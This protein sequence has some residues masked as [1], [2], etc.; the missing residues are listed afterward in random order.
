METNIMPPCSLR[1]HTPRSP[2]PIPISL[3]NS[4]GRLITLFTALLMLNTMAILFAPGCG[5]SGYIPSSTTEQQDGDVNTDATT[6]GDTGLNDEGDSQAPQTLEAVISAHPHIINEGADTTTIV[7]L[8]GS[9]SRNPAGGTL[10]YTWDVPGCTIIEGTL[11]SSTIRCAFTGEEPKEL[12]LTVATSA[13]GAEPR[14]ATCN[15]FLPLNLKPQV[16][17]DAPQSANRNTPAII[18]ATVMDPETGPTE[19]HFSLGPGFPPGASLTTV[20]ETQ[21]ELLSPAPGKVTINATASDTMGAT[22]SSSITIAITNQAPILDFIGNRTVRAGTRLSFTTTASDP[23][24]DPVTFLAENLPDRATYSEGIFIWDTT[25][26]HIGSQTITFKAWDGIDHSQED[27]TLTVLTIPGEPVLTLSPPDLY[28]RIGA[29]QEL[30]IVAGAWTSAGTVAAL[31]ASPLPTGATFTP[32]TG[33]FYWTPTPDQTGTH[34]ITFKVTAGAKSTQSTVTIM[35]TPAEN[36]PPILAMNPDHLTWTISEG[37]KMEFHIE[38]TDPDGDQVT[39]GVSGLPANA[40]FNSQG[41]TGQ[42]TFTPSYSQAGVL[43]MII[44]ASDGHLVT[45]TTITIAIADV[46]RPPTMNI[47]PGPQV[48]ALTGQVV[49]LKVNAHDPDGDTVQ[50]QLDQSPLGATMDPATAILTWT[51]GGHQL[52]THQVIFRAMDNGNPPQ[53]TTATAVINVRQSNRS[54]VVT[55]PLPP[56]EIHTGGTV[57]ID[58][59]LYFNDPDGDTLTYSLPAKPSWVTI[60]PPSSFIFIS[61]RDPSLAMGTWPVTARASDGKA[62]ADSTF[63]VSVI[64]SPVGTY[65]FHE[66]ATPGDNNPDGST[67]SWPIGSIH[68][69]VMGTAGDELYFASHHDGERLAIHRVHNNAMSPHK[70][71]ER[72]NRNEFREAFRSFGTFLP[73]AQGKLAFIGHTWGYSGVFIID[74]AQTPVAPPVALVRQ[75]YEAPGGLRIGTVGMDSITAN[76]DFG[77]CG[78][79]FGLPDQRAAFVYS[80]GKLRTASSQGSAAP[81]GGNFSTCFGTVLMGGGGHVAFQANLSG[82]KWGLFVWKPGNANGPGVGHGQWKAAWRSDGSYSF[83]ALTAINQFMVRADGSVIFEGSTAAGK[84]GIFVAPFTD[85]YPP[86]KL[87]MEG[88]TIQGSG[89][90]VSSCSLFN[91]RTNERSDT[92]TVMATISFDGKDGDATGIYSIHIETGEVM[93]VIVPG[94]R[95]DGGLQLADVFPAA[96]SSPDSD[97][98]IFGFQSSPSGYAGIGMHTTES[99]QSATVSGAKAQS[100]PNNIIVALIGDNLPDGSQFSTPVTTLGNDSGTVY[101]QQTAGGTVFRGAAEQQNN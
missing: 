23:D 4:L 82:G 74:M 89:D 13:S 92:T 26:E 86:R 18:E 58:L 35:V 22:G 62:T 11:H 49:I 8:D 24:G 78:T 64:R 39:L 37:E 7:L 17:L 53:S 12:S 20:S 77:W 91:S 27:V 54:P 65:T 43:Q 66:V 14:E 75:N 101:F 90:V 96:V 6:E 71:I 68:S 31:E 1:S 98:I 94:D 10:S 21:A 52:G 48:V 47:T 69:P 3:P 99:G 59:N 56:Q 81:G 25:P 42:F 67:G 44:T 55:T 87:V 70:V 45:R 76:L 32:E 80:G 84:Q 95:L 51:P 34:E 40:T 5:D 38:A 16:F 88:N 63:Q 15:L 9:T 85:S 57:A 36:H 100:I 2:M 50:L 61:P 19:I 41:S 60:A 79:P 73:V 29:G 30:G 33:Q 97:R 28:H 93:G 83:G 72:Y 46:N